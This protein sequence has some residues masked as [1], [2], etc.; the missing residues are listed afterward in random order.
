M[1]LTQPCASLLP[2]TMLD[3]SVPLLPPKIDYKN[4]PQKDWRNTV[5]NLKVETVSNNQILLQEA[6][7]KLSPTRAETNSDQ[8]NAILGENH[9][10]L[11]GK[12]GEGSFSKVNVATHTL[13]G[14]K[15]NN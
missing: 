5:P 10:V 1:T 8:E 13:T 15:V 6:L 9:I 4:I 14:S 3:L 11:E 2:V 12:I 7:T